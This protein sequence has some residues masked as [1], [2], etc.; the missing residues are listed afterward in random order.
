MAN[1][2]KVKFGL[3]NVY[4]A[5]ATIADDG[6]A[7]YA[8]PVRLPGAV[9]LSLEAQGENTPFYADNIAYWTSTGNAGYEG[10]FELALIPD[11]FKKDVLGYKE[12]ASGILYEPAGAPTVNF[13]LLFQFEGD[14][15]ATRHV[16]Y[17]CTSGRPGIGSETTT[18]STE[19][20]TETLAISATSIYNAATDEN[21][22]KARALTTDSAYSTWFESV[23]T[24]TGSSGNSV[25]PSSGTGGN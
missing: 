25:T 8:T 19:P 15:N 7:T 23:T 17:N 24:P 3:S 13:A 11:S 10:D 4:Y 20:T 1:T 2:N 12:D 21:I 18:D 5:V 6:S 22:V 9:N 14:K 16:L